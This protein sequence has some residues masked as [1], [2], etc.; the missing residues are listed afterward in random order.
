MEIQ[1]I[2]KQFG[3]SDKEISVYLALIELGPAPVRQISLGA[4][5]N[6][7][8]TYDILKGLMEQGLVSYFNKATKQYFV[9]EPPEKLLS[10]VE[11]KLNHLTELKTEI[12]ESLPTLK[13]L[14]EREGGKP[15]VKLY[16]GLAGIRQILKDVLDSVPAVSDK[17]YFVYSSAGV[18]KN[19]L[20]AMP[21]FTYA[22]IKK[23]IK[24]QSIALGGGGQ[25]VGLDE[26]KWMHPELAADSLKATYELIYAGRVGHI[27]L[28][29]AGSPVGVVIANQ[30]IYETQKMI[31][32]FNWNAI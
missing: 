9:A 24:V 17:T 15:Q 2:L 4:K 13:T 16:E 28:D 5:V 25:L 7:G 27:S 12:N 31:F 18:R 30:E 21:D 20:Q 14:F 8:T 29:T 32:S 11:G 19:V 6:R 1:P 26:R 22:R 23:G 3:L 10:A